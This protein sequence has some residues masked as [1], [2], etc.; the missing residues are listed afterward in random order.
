MRPYSLVAS[1]LTCGLLLLVLASIS[2]CQSL[3][4]SILNYQNSQNAWIDQPARTIENLNLVIVSSAE[5]STAANARFNA[6]AK[7]LEDLAN[8]CSFI[9][10]GTHFE[11]RYDTK[12]KEKSGDRFVSYVKIALELKLCNQAKQ[13]L[14][15]DQIRK[16]ANRGYTEE[17]QQYQQSQIV[18]R[19]ATKTETAAAT[20]D[21]INS[22]TESIH[23]DGEFFTTRQKLAMLKQELILSEPSFDLQESVHNQNRLQAL[24]DKFLIAQNYEQA[25]PALSSGTMTWSKMKSQLDRIQKNSQQIFLKRKPAQTKNR[26]KMSRDP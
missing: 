24:S 16:M 3:S 14:N 8:E 15:A 20:V 26:K 25:N 18:S 22:D 13:L 21:L 9:S 10:K 19:P 4:V 6:E 1:F 7:G 17:I 11:A 5:E 2:A 23:D 12:I